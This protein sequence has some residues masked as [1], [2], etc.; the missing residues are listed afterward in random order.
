MIV[1]K[2]TH[3]RTG[4][5]YIGSTTGDRKNYHGGGVIWNRA[6]KKHGLDSFQYEVIYEGSDARAMEEKILTELN[7]ADDPMSYNMKNVAFGFG[8]GDDHF[9]ARQRGFSDE[10]R[11]NIRKSRLGK[12]LSNETKKKLSQALSG[13]KRGAMSEERKKLISKTLKTSSSFNSMHNNTY[14]CI[15]PDGEEHIVRT[16]GRWIEWCKSHNLDHCVMRKVAL[17]KTKK[18]KHKGWTC[19]LL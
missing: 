3:K 7:A 14:R 2:Y 19:E 10:H 15:S 13:K 4:K 18:G 8:I 12:P 16:N 11:E 5:Y 6:L 1:Y 9:S 17:G